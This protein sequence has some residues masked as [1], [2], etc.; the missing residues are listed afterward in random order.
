MGNR[1]GL[2]L[3]LIVAGACVII[4]AV[5]LA[6]LLVYLDSQHSAPTG[7]PGPIIIF[8]MIAAIGAG[9]VGVAME[10]IGVAI[11]VWPRRDGEGKP[12]AQSLT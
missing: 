9:I 4:A 3:G 1:M 5:G 12:E 2:A 8:T 6:A 10:V 11:G 7:S